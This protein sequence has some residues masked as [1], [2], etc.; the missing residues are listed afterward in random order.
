MADGQ[1]PVEILRSESHEGTSCLPGQHVFFTFKN[2]NGTAVKLSQV[3]W[4]KVIKQTRSQG[5]SSEW[6]LAPSY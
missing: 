6:I 2:S 4:L 5:L 3:G 1:A